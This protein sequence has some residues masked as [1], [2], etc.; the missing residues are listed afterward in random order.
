[1]RFGVQYMAAG[2]EFVQKF[3]FLDGVTD[4]ELGAFF[5]GFNKWLE[6]PR[7]G[8]MSAKGFGLFSADTVCNFTVSEINRLVEEYENFI[9]A[10]GTDVLSILETKKVKKNGKTSNKTD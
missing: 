5:A 4:L 2:T 3:I 1:M 10:Q 6:V 7:L 9:K 8:G